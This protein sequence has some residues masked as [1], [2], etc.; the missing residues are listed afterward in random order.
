[1]KFGEVCCIE[2]PSTVMA[3]TAY[4]NNAATAWPHAPGV[5]EAVADALRLMPIHAGRSSGAENEVLLDCRRQLCALFKVDNPDRI[6]LTANATQSL[7]QVIFGLELAAGDH[8]VTSQAEHNSVLRPLHHLKR[9]RGIRLDIVGFGED[10]QLDVDAF[11]ELIDNKTRLVVLNHV[12]NVTGEQL[13][14]EEIFSHAKSFG[15]ITVLDASQSLGCIHVWAQPLQ[16]D[17]IVFTGHKGLRGPPGTGGFY[18]APGINLAQVMVGGTG[19]RSDLEL[20]PEEMPIRLEAG[21][22][23]LPGLSGLNVAL[24]WLNNE[25]ARFYQQAQQKTAQMR[26]ALQQIDGI[27][28]FG[29]ANPEINSGII[30]FQIN[31]WSVAEAGQALQE[32]FGIICRSGLHCAPLIHSAIGSAPEGTIRFSLSGF[33]TEE[34]INWAIKAVQKLAECKS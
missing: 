25:G 16:A 17:I 13:P 8:V 20:H 5:P 12:S 27:S 7:N 15:A 14:V 22:P 6:I 19:V 18:V 24:R 1:L 34:E 4:F 9:D 10:G 32:S 2:N 30:S 21:T 33:T 26:N 28:I 31:G 23:N 3:V 29:R 11:K